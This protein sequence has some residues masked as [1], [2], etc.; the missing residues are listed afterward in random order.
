MSA[1]RSTLPRRTRPIEAADFKRAGALIVHANSFSVPD[2][3]DGELNVW[4]RTIPFLPQTVQKLYEDIFQTDINLEIHFLKEHD[5]KPVDGF[6]AVSVSS[7][8][9]VEFKGSVRF[10]HGR[11]LDQEGSSFEVVPKARGNGLGKAWLKSMVELT[12]AF[13]NEDLKFQ[14]ASENGSFTW[15]KAGVPMDM[16]PEKGEKRANL[17]KMVIGRLEAIRPYISS[18]DYHT[19]RA[20]ARFTMKHD[21]NRLASMTAVVPVAV[22]EDLHKAESVEGQKPH[23]VRAFESAAL[24]GRELSLPR[25]LL[26][27]TGWDARIDF[28][29]E[30]EMETIGN[31]LGGWKTIEPVRG[32]PVQQLVPSC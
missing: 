11:K 7:P 6:F 4:D 24:Q 17:S 8:D 25:F 14:A 9:D 13:G 32:Q 26:S 27:Y 22:L 30:T 18:S 19:A 16:A 29:K 10:L 12:L 15:G 2:S 3:M 5:N 28:S 31:Y 20:M 23:L 21:I 1:Y